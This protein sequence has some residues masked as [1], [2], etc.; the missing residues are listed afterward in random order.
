M[1]YTRDPETPPEPTTHPPANTSNQHWC[2]QNRLPLHSHYATQS[3]HHDRDSMSVKTESTKSNETSA[4]VQQPQPS[5]APPST[6]TSSTTA[7][8][9]GQPV[10]TL[11]AQPAPRSSSATG[12]LQLSSHKR[13]EPD[14][15][16]QSQPPTS[17]VIHPSKLISTSNSGNASDTA[18]PSGMNT[19]VNAHSG[20]GDGGDTSMDMMGDDMWSGAEGDAKRPRLRLAHAC[21]RCR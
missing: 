19:P 5:R 17:L 13:N 2:D 15:I 21:D 20:D 4:P 3:S 18:T 12:N 7:N 16:T 6:S 1:V 8:S 11:Q 10:Q 9:G 14:R